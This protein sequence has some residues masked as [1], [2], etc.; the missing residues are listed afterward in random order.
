MANVNLDGDLWR[1]VR[2]RAA[3]NGRS[4]SSVV[5]EAVT[6]WLASDQITTV[7][8]TLTQSSDTSQTYRMDPPGA[9]VTF[10]EPTPPIEDREDIKPRATTA[11]KK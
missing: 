1:R 5:T 2:V 11:R 4:A 10:A 3:E 9:L 7:H 6:M 8:G